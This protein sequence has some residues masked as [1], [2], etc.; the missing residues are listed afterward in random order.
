LL[1]G[2]FSDSLFPNWK[3]SVAEKTVDRIEELRVFVTI[4]ES[5]GFAPAARRLG[6]SAAQASKLVARLEDRLNTRL[7]NRTTRDV[8]LTDSGR[9]LHARARVLVEEYDL[10]ER[11]AHETAAP[12]GL[13]RLSA[14]V[15][16]GIQQLGSVLSDFAA[17]Y[18]DVGLEVHFADRMVN[19]VDEGFDVAVRIGTLLDSSLIAR[20]LTTVRFVTVASPEYLT[21]R[22]APRR[23]D[24]ITNHNIILDLNLPDTSVWVFGK[25]SKRTEVRLNSQLRF[26]NPYI[27]VA[28]TR[29]GLGITRVPAF[30]AAEDLRNGRLTALLR[31]HEPDPA[32]IYAVYPHA[33]HLASKVRVFVD[34]LAR[35]FAGEPEW[36]RGW[37]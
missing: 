16:F 10:L 35:R 23:P 18:P 20:K 29:A 24:D 6:I 22:A 21:K 27:C 25:G 34:F 37:R 36:H 14:P 8:S 1:I 31:Q 30:A 33:R 9:I 12:R 17:A 28:A 4:A 7:F 19:L 13:L 11:S 3:Y 5:Q 26:S 15:S 2:S 32:T